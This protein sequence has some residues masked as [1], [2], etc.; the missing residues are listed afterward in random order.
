MQVA[1]NGAT[2]SIAAQTAAQK[3]S[4]TLTHTTTVYRHQSTNQISTTI[5]LAA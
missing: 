1:L 2:K 4:V 5:N 3:H